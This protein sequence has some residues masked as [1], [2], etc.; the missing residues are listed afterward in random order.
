MCTRMSGLRLE[1]YRGIRCGF[2][3]RNAK[4]KA[5][6]GA[7]ITRVRESSSSD[8]SNAKTVDQICSVDR[9]RSITLLFRSLHIR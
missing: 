8:V 9:E 2:T 1:T 5:N 6:E 4:N 7:A 3:L